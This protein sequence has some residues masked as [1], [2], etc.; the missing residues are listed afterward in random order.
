MNTPSDVSKL[1]VNDFAYVTLTCIYS[2]NRSLIFLFQKK[3]FYIERQSYYSII[4]TIH[5][6]ARPYFQ[7]FK[8]FW[9]V[10]IFFIRH[11]HFHH[12]GSIIFHG[13]GMTIFSSNDISC[14]TVTCPCHRI[15]T[16]ISLKRQCHVIFCFRFFHESSSPKPQKKTTWSLSIFFDN[17]L[18]AAQVCTLF[19]STVNPW[20]S[21]GSRVY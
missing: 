8:Q 5:V 13:I 6:S 19:S 17:S 20:E 3:V 1:S 21:Y 18:C 2:T 7:F 10:W 9:L 15:I 4:T 12:S 14:D 16:C 11:S